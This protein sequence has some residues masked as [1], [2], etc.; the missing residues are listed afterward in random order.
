VDLYVSV[1]VEAMRLSDDS[2][3][4]VAEW[5]DPSDSGYFWYAGQPARFRS[6]HGEVVASV[7]SWLVRLGT[8]V[9]VVSDADFSEVFTPLQ[10]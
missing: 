10:R 3:R 1:P 5:L 9:A 6:P 7:G 8:S 2:I 4:A